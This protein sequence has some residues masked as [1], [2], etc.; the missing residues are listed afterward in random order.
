MAEGCRQN[1]LWNHAWATR[2]CCWS[3]SLEHTTSSL[4]TVED[5]RMLDVA[6]VWEVQ[7]IPLHFLEA[8]S[9]NNEKLK[10]K[11]RHAQWFA[12]TYSLFH[13]LWPTCLARAKV[14]EKMASRS[15]GTANIKQA[16]SSSNKGRPPNREITPDLHQESESLFT[17][18]LLDFTKSLPP[19]KRVMQELKI[20]VIQMTK[21]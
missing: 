2:C 4:S 6:S 15:G 13:F 10:K 8:C 12:K 20:I 16:E 5:R 17:L 18:F 9:D 7:P 3:P 19:Q 1:L 14:V 11:A 21:I